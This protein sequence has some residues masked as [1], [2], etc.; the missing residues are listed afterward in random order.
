MSLLCCIKSFFDGI[1]RHKIA[2]AVSVMCFA[3]GAILGAVCS[4]PDSI[5][6]YL[7]DSA[8]RYFYFIFSYENGIWYVFFFRFFSYIFFLAPCFL[9]IVSPLCIPI[10]CFCHLVCGYIFTI[11]IVILCDY[12]AVGVF[13]M[14]SA[15][16]PQRLCYSFLSCTLTASLFRIKGRE[17]VAPLKYAAM[18]GGICCAAFLALAAAECAVLFII[19]RPFVIAL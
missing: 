5:A 18:C 11:N 19:F 16:L 13:I 15:Y 8:D 10:N 17:S 1:F 3:A 4:P 12:S 9:I 2:F 14:L 7:S 6:C